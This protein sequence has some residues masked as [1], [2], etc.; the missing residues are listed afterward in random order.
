MAVEWTSYLW[1]I[2]IVI[3]GL[4]IYG[5]AMFLR[6]VRSLEDNSK[7]AIL[8]VLLSLLMEVL[9]GVFARIFLMKQISY[10]SYVWFVLPFFGLIGAYFLILGAKKFLSTA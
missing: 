7:W 5:F 6:A 1:Q 10:E 9:Q 8:L 2:E 3:I 4:F